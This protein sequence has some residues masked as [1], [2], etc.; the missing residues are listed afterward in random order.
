M[1]KTKLIKIIQQ[2]NKKESHAM[3]Q[4]LASVIHSVNTYEEQN[5]IDY[6]VI[7]ML[8]GDARAFRKYVLEFQPDVDLTFFPDDGGDSFPLPI[9]IRF[10]YPDFE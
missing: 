8:A 6:F 3:S 2:D 4:Q 10:F 7:N 1:L 9:G 5:V